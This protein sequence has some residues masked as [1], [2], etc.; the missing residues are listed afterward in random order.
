MVAALIPSELSERTEGSAYLIETVC[1]ANARSD[2]R[3]LSPKQLNL[4]VQTPHAISYISSVYG[5][6]HMT[7]ADAICSSLEWNSQQE[8]E[9]GKDRLASTVF[10]LIVNVIYKYAHKKGCDQIDNAFVFD[11]I[12]ALLALVKKGDEPDYL[13]VQAVSALLKCADRW[14]SKVTTDYPLGVPRQATASSHSESPV[15]EQQPAESEAESDYE[16][17]SSDEDSSDEE[18]APAAE[19][20]EQQQDEDGSSS[21]EEDEDEDEEITETQAH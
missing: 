13:A 21:T 15:P 19:E 3:M 14:E 1:N 10:T 8:G 11:A 18:D 2:Q 4:N 9:E 16:K 7:M 5:T 12:D 20:E 17:F 6:T